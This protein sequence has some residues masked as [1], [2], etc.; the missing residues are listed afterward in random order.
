M[1]VRR[2]KGTVERF[3]TLGGHRAAPPGHQSDIGQGWGDLWGAQQ[4]SSSQNARD[5]RLA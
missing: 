3:S 2:F 4:R 5:P 1:R